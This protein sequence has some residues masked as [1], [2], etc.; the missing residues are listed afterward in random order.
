[1][2][3][4]PETYPPPPPLIPTVAIQFVLLNFNNS[5][6]PRPQYANARVGSLMQPITSSMPPRLLLWTCCNQYIRHHWIIPW[7]IVEKPCLHTCL[8]AAVCLIMQRR[9][10]KL[11]LS[12][13]KTNELFGICTKMMPSICHLEIR[14]HQ[15]AARRRKLDVV[16]KLCRLASV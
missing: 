8:T 3:C 1:M 12:K 11:M 15:E 16:K 2:S 6:P 7:L 4:V 5:L 13:T 10:H 9:V 14:D